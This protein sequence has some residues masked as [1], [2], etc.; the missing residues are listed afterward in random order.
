MIDPITLEQSNLCLQLAM[1]FVNC[2]SRDK[3]SHL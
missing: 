1:L 2:V 3:P